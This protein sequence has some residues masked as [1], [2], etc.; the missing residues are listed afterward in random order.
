[1]N[2]ARIKD[3][4]SSVLCPWHEDQTRDPSSDGKCLVAFSTTTAGK[5]PEARILGR[6]RTTVPEVVPPDVWENSALLACVG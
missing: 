1:M 5:W 4:G 6:Y 3:W 2:V